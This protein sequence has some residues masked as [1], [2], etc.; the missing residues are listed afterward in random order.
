MTLEA[1]KKIEFE[2]NEFYTIL[3]KLKIFVG[4]LNQSAMIEL[5]LVEEQRKLLRQSISKTKTIDVSYFNH[6]IQHARYEIFKYTVYNLYK[7]LWLK[8][9]F[10]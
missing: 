6:L 9:E 7:K 10:K 8:I 5:A 1:W 4:S 2:T 3:D